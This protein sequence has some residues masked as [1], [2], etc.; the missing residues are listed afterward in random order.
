MIKPKSQYNTLCVT[1]NVLLGNQSE[2]DQTLP[3]ML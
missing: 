1:Q 3:H 2:F